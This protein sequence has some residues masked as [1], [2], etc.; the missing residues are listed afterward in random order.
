V[1]LTRSGHASTQVIIVSRVVTGIAITVGKL[2]ALR[3]RTQ[4]TGVAAGWVDGLVRLTVWVRNTGQR[5]TKGTGTISCAMGAAA[6]SFGLLMDTVLPGQGA[7]LPVNAA[8][9]RAG[10]WRCAARIE[11]A[12][13]GSAAWT[14]DRLRAGHRAGRDQAGRPRRAVRG[15]AAPRPGGGPPGW[16]VA[17]IVIGGLILFSLWAVLL[18]RK[19]DKDRDPAG[20][21]QVSETGEAGGEAR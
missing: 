13:G 8:G 16:A 15:G 18:R 11:D 21:G 17:P 12:G 6:H 20:P 1:P 9:L 19:R 10:A 4:I 2:A 7:G 3:T 14:G 5:F